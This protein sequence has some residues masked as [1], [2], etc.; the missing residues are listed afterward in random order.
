MRSV[1]KTA[2]SQQGEAADVHLASDTHN[3]EH[4]SVCPSGGERSALERLS[5]KI[6]PFS[7]VPPG[8]LRGHTYTHTP[9]SLSM[10][11]GQDSLHLY[12]MNYNF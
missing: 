10:Q 2:R 9:E 7:Q 1:E 6:S 5:L 11:A 4:A 3:P 8:G 12:F